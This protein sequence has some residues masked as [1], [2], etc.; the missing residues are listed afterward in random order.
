MTSLAAILI[1]LSVQG[2]PDPQ[3]IR[4]VYDT[5]GAEQMQA[6]NA[7]LNNG[8]LTD[9]AFADLSAPARRTCIQ[10]GVWTQQHQITASYLY[11][12]SL[13][14]FVDSGQQLQSGGIDPDAVLQ[15]WDSLPTA[16][17]A[18]LK[19]G[20]ESYPDGDDRFV[21]DIRTFLVAQ[22]PAREAPHLGRALGLLMSYG[23]MLRFQDDY[24]SPAGPTQ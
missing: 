18:A 2:A 13:A 20:V 12:L 9:A 21:A 23:E 10:Q 16:L 19:T 22:T 14:R 24:D 8:S 4:C 7:Q 5:V 3:G 1:A 15:Q 11:A 17:R 6:Y